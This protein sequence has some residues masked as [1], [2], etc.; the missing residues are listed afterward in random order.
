MDPISLRSRHHAP[1]NESLASVHAPS[2]RLDATAASTNF[3]P[4]APSRSFGN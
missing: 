1:S 4:M 2:A 3:T